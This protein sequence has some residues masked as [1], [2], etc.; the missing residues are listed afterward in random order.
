MSDLAV[1]ADR[2]AE[3]VA[4]I[5]FEPAFELTLTFDSHVEQTP[6][7][8][9]ILRKITGGRV[10]GKI[11]G[12]VYPQGGGEYSLR[13]GDGVIDVHT[14]AMI[15]DAKG[16]W[17]YLRI[18]GYSRPDGYYRVTSWVDADVRGDHQWVLGLFFVG[19]ADSVTAKELKLR[20]AEVT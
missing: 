2:G 3:Y 14:H 5:G 20:F 1:A 19:V 9:R 13:R 7:G 6:H 8:E 10:S 15:R 12:V 11:E 16:E 4:E 18:I 17:L